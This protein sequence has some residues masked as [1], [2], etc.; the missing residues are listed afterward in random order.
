MCVDRRFVKTCLP[1]NLQRALPG[2][3]WIRCIITSMSGSRL[4]VKRERERRYLTAARRNS[5]VLSDLSVT[6]LQIFGV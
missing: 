1:Q 4:H 2:E 6:P 5:H 3:M